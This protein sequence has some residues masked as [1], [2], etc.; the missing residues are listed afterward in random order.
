MARSKKV[1][2]L[3]KNNYRQVVPMLRRWTRSIENGEY[4][5]VGSVALV[6]LG[7]KLRVFGAGPD[8]DPCTVAALLQAGNIKIVNRIVNHGSDD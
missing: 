6:I 3:Y 8:A 5:E 4:G 1:V 2:T 7:D